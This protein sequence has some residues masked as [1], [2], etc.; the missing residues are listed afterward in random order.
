MTTLQVSSVAV[1]QPLDPEMMPALC[2]AADRSRAVEPGLVED[3]WDMPDGIDDPAALCASVRSLA[4]RSYQVLRQATST[5]MASLRDVSELL[6][7]VAQFERQ[8]DEF[9]RLHQLPLEELRS[10]I[11]SLRRRIESLKV[12]PS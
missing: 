1:S 5:S 11:S 3:H 2:W 8:I 6:K 10:W 7:R 12:R 4:S 9:R